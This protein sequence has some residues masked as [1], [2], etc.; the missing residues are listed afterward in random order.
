MTGNIY[1]RY[2]AFQAKIR[3]V[4][5]WTKLRSINCCWMHV[6]RPLSFIADNFNEVKLIESSVFRGI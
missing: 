3:T 6:I 5:P 1:S 4:Y 2:S